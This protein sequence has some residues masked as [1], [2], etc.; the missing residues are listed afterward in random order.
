MVSTKRSLIDARAEYIIP[1]MVEHC[2]GK[3]SRKTAAQLSE[4][5]GSR[6]S[7]EQLYTVLR[8]PCY[9]ERIAKRLGYNFCHTPHTYGF[10]VEK[11]EDKKVAT[12]SKDTHGNSIRNRLMRI[13]SHSSAIQ[14]ELQEILDYAKNKDK[15]IKMQELERQKSKIDQ[16]LD[17]LKGG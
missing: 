3:N 1:Y 5:T 9:G 15:Y 8:N 11:I 6:Y 10:W 13:S 2:V 7:V 16:E 17:K 4:E 14:I 12:N